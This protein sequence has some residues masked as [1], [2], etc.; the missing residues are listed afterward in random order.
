[1]GR[2]SED[3]DGDENGCFFGWSESFGSHWA[4][5]STPS[6]RGGGS[7]VTPRP[8]SSHQDKKQ[9]VPW[10]PWL[11]NLCNQR[12]CRCLGARVSHCFMSASRV[13]S[14]MLLSVGGL[15]F[16][17]CHY[18]CCRP[19]Q[20]PP[21]RQSTV[22]GEIGRCQVQQGSMRDDRVSAGETTAV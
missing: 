19:V 9:R 17:L 11:A 16:C 5:R 6:R 8:E 22:A 2:D 21:Q 4:R 18:C 13:A 15:T 10:L 20:R 1:M 12:T 14:A 7:Y 3:E